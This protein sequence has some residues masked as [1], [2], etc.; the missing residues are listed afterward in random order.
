MSSFVTMTKKRM[1]SVSRNARANSESFQILLNGRIQCVVLSCLG[2]QKNMR[3]TFALFLLK[4]HQR[5]C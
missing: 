5:T 2:M 4:A 1:K 3:H